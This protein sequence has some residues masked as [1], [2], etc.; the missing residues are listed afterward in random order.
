MA[1]PGGKPEWK[2]DNVGTLELEHEVEILDQLQPLFLPDVIGEQEG[3]SVIYDQIEI[4]NQLPG[5]RQDGDNANDTPE[6]AELPIDQ[7]I[8]KTSH[9]PPASTDKTYESG[10]AED[11][12][13]Q[14][15]SSNRDTKMTNLVQSFNERVAGKPKKNIQEATMGIWDFAGHEAFHTTHQTFLTR[16]AIYLLVADLSKEINTDGGSFCQA[17]EWL[18]SI[19][20][21]VPRSTAAD[22]TKTSNA[23]DTLVT[24]P[25]AATSVIYPIPDPAATLSI[26]GTHVTLGEVINAT[27]PVILVGTHV[28]KIPQSRR[29]ERISRYWKKICNILKDKPT[30]QHLVDF[31]AIDNTKTDPQLKT[32]QNKI[33]QLARDQPYWGEEVPTS[34]ILMEERFRNLR[35]HGKKVISLSELGDIDNTLPVPIQNKDPT[36]DLDVFLRFQHVIGN[37][38]YFSAEGLREIIVLDPQW[39]VDAQKS[40]ITTETFIHE[41]G[42]DIECKWL[43]FRQQ[44]KLTHEI[45]DSFWTEENNLEFHDKK[46]IILKLLEQLNIIT[47]PWT[48]TEDGGKMEADYFLVPCMLSREPPKEITSP[49]QDT[50]LVNSSILSFVF[51]G[52]FLP[53]P[54]FHRLL[55]ACVAKW[56]VAKEKSEYLI[57]SGYCIF[58]L[59]L[60]HRLTLCC[61]NHVVFARITRMVIDDTRT[62]D[63]KWCTRVRKFI[64]LSLKTIISYLDQNLPFELY[65]Q[66]LPSCGVSEDGMVSVASFQM[67]YADEGESLTHEHMNYGRLCIAMSSVCTEA[68]KKILI[69]HVP[70]NYLNINQAILA[71]RTNLSSRGPLNMQQIALVFP[72]PHCKTVGCLD[73][74][75]ISLLYILIR[76]VSSVTEPVT[77]WGHPPTDQ[78]SRDTTLGASVERI[79]LCRNDMIAHNSSGMITKSLFDA[80]WNNIETTICEIECVLGGN[81]WSTLL[82]R[83]R[84]CVVTIYEAHNML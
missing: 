36:K 45:I 61:R 55:A 69:T 51:V 26:S 37:I 16:H 28:D 33:V 82:E 77:G 23:T 50:R 49:G 7:N 34:Y 13:R 24:S 9:Q 18:N 53:P 21:C 5:Q 27:P 11:K 57:F 42:P 32:L 31:I 10:T 60:F 68:L 15:S 80:F 76:N 72:D 56:Q 3:P 64:T 84:K 46:E 2:L 39:L 62:L 6:S 58:D 25:S 1:A 79:R 59:D 19:H 43:E 70:V 35:A 40:L 41:K 73:D 63:T 67:W 12:S 30:L 78:P 38:I 20:C 71:N 44:G 81:V 8:D 52:K 47:R 54:I 17:E 65:I 83:Q 4:I 66:C 14:H 22:I 48:F 74:F 29:Q 75:D